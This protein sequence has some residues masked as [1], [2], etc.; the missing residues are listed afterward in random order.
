VTITQTP[1]GAPSRPARGRGALV[2]VLAT[3]L[4]LAVAAGMLVIGVTARSD[5]SDDHGRADAASAGRD[6]TAAEQ[7]K[8]DGRRRAL[9]TLTDAVPSRVGELEAALTAVVTAQNHYIDVVNTA[10]NQSMAGDGVGA[11][12]TLRA[13][14]QTALEGLTA[15][16]ADVQQALQQARDALAQL[17]AAR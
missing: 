11:A 1:T 6:R 4:M 2:A 5:A 8:V 13:Q 14:G 16:N 7:A 9:R 17:E 15:R 10:S 12:A 3:A